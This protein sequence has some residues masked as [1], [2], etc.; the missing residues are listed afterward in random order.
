[1]EFGEHAFLTYTYIYIW[2]FFNAFLASLPWSVVSLVFWELLFFSLPH[3]V[4][5]KLPQ[6]W[7]E[8]MPSALEAWSLNHWTT[9]EAQNTAFFFFLL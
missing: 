6:S 5:V 2:V 8:P 9:R 1:M 3:C 4:L 7:I